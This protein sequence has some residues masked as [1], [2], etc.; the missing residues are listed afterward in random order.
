MRNNRVGA[1]GY[2]QFGSAD[3]FW[4]RWLNVYALQVEPACHRMKLEVVLPAVEA[5]HV[6]H[7]R[8]LDKRA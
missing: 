4:E 3:W 5:A 1:T 7:M 2:L 8:V 6:Q